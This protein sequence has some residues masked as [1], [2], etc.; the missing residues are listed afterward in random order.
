M[1][2]PF[3]ALL[4]MQTKSSFTESGS[5]SIEVVAILG[6]DFTT[7]SL[8]QMLRLALSLENDESNQATATSPQVAL[9]TSTLTVRQTS[10]T[11]RRRVSLGNKI[12]RP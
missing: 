7:Q 11:L 9:H 2:F 10:V 3:E 1:G 8:I 12:E 4:P 6:P 5:D